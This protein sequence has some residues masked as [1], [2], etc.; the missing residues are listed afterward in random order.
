M[1][2][3]RPMF[4]PRADFAAPRTESSPFRRLSEREL[5]PKDV[6]TDLFEEELLPDTAAIADLVIQRL[7]DAGFEIRPAEKEARHG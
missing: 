1:T 3:E 5:D 7:R 2:T 4:P 6:L